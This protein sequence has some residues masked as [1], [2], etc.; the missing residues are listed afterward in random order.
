MKDI[1][2]FHAAI[3]LVIAF[4]IFKEYYQLN[5]PF[6]SMYVQ[7]DVDNRIYNVVGGFTDRKEAANRLSLVHN[8][9][10]D[11][12]KYLKKKFIVQNNG[13]INDQ[14]FITRILNNYKPDKLK[15]NYPKP[16]EDTSY[17]LNKGDEF[18]MCLRS[19]N[20]ATKDKFHD[21]ELL[22]FVTLHEI[23]HLGTKTFGHNKE[24]W[25]SFKFILQQAEES[26][27]YIPV[28]YSQNPQL[29]CGILVSSN[30]YYF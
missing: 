4:L 18:G 9:M 17:V 13:T 5:E 21:F 26:G 19:K 10:I 29:Y 14:K 12:M 6:T 22:K 1:C 23:T 7:S 11:Y 25:D 28:D 2:I 30:P 20:D 15:E 24:F 27:L 3:I 8:F 16:G